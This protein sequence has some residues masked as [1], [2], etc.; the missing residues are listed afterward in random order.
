MVTALPQH[1][2]AAIAKLQIVLHRLFYNQALSLVVQDLLAQ[3]L[4]RTRRQQV[5]AVR[6]D[7]QLQRRCV[8][9][10]HLDAVVP[11]RRRLA[12]LLGDDI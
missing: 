7:L 5:R 9:L 6:L 12:A 1:L 4:L 10:L 8:Q 2:I 11:L 3:R